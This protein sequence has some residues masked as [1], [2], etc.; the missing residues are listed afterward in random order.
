MNN[1][2]NNIEYKRVWNNFSYTDTQI[3]KKTNSNIINGI[4]LTIF[5]I[6]NL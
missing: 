5:P 2:N 6:I 3:E 1:T 4:I